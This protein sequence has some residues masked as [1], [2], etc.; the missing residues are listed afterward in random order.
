MIVLW[1]FLFPIATLHAATAEGVPWSLIM[2]Q[3]LNFFFLV[4]ILFFILRKPLQN[5]LLQRRS[6]FLKFEEQAQEQKKEAERSLKGWTE[7]LESVNTSFDSEIAKAG[8]QATTNREQWVAEAKQQAQK[9]IQ[10]IQESIDL[11]VYKAKMKLTKKLFDASTEWA[12]QH[13]QK[14]EGLKKKVIYKMSGEHSS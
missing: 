14:T 8:D 2:T 9:Y 11:E 1:F 7:R 3:A 4:A 5:I 6:E 10:K 13:S 12:V